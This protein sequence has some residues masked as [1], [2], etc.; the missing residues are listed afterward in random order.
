[1]T[2]LADGHEVGQLGQGD[3]ATITLGAERSRLGTLPEV[4]FF[5]RYRNTFA[6]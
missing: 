5:R 2:V 6:S 1:V 4:T 3:R